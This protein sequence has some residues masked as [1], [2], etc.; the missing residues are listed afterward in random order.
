MQSGVGCAFRDKQR[1]GVGCLAVVRHA[2]CVELVQ[3]EPMGE[4]RATLGGAEPLE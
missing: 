1:G 3:Q 4:V 2:P